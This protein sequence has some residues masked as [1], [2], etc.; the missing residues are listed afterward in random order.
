[1]NAESRWMAQVGSLASVA[2][3]YLHGVQV[4]GVGC[5][6]HRTVIPHLPA[7]MATH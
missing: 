7:L 3:W 2:G 4:L 5:H 6:L 1:M